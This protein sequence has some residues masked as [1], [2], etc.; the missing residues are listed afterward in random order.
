MV[1]LREIYNIVKELQSCSSTKAKQHILSK[2]KDNELFREI[3]VRT[4]DTNLQYGIKQKTVDKMKFTT[5]EKDKWNTNVW[6]MLEELADSNINNTLV[7]EVEKLLCY[8]DDE[9][10]D[11]IIRVLLKDLRCNISVKTINT[12]IPGLIHQHQVMLASKFEGKIKGKVSMSL[13]MDGI[14]NSALIEKG[15]IKHVSRQ[16]KVVDGLEEINNALREFDLDGY[17]VDGELIRINKE[18]IPSDDNFR[19]TTKIVNSKSFYKEA[20][21]F[22]VFDIVPIEDYY[23]GKSGL[24]YEKRLQLME[25]LIGEGNEFIRL[26]PKFGITDNVD[27]IYEKLHEVTSNGDEGIMLNTLSGVYAF[28]KRPKDILKVKKFE[29]GD[30]LVT[31]VLEGE[32]RLKGKLGKI[33]VQFKYENN[34]YT[35]YIGSGFSDDEREYFWNNKEKL[36]GKIITIKYFELS[37]NEKGG[38]GFRFGTWKGKEYIREDKEGIDDTNV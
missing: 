12:A 33:E 7:W 24:T 9:S 5:T 6:K 15:N 34:I 14:R 8:F 1:G 20:L 26:V 36:I 28:G 18:G 13:K 2:N 32:G 30:V 23:M 35:N 11:L 4:Y 17:F 21:E 38:I 10:R 25:E 27:E 31:D 16:G 37:K 29:D 19:L 3:L 22:V